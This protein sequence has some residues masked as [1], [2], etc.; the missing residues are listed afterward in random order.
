MNKSLCSF[1][2][3]SLKGTF[4]PKWEFATEL[5][6]RLFYLKS[7]DEQLLFCAFDTL[8]TW[9]SDTRKFRKEIS[10]A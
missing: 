2:R 8:G 3:V 10:A 7:G 5:Y 9:A 1:G 4:T 6:V